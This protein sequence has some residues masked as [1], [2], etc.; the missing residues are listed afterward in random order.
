MNVIICETSEEMSTVAAGL[1]AERIRA[2]PD[3]V[4][5]LATGSTPL[6]MYC[7]LIR[8]HTEEGLGFATVRTFNLDEYVGLPPDHDQSYRRFMDANLFDHINIEKAN[9]RVPDGQAEDLAA[10][11]A[12][13][14][15]DIRSAG[16][17]DLQLLG[18]GSNGHIAFNEPGS[19][20]DS[21]TRVVD[22]TENTIRDNARFFERIEDVP[23]Q[24]VSMGMGSIMDARQVVL[25]ASGENK[26][27]AVATTLEGPVTEEVPA[28]ILQG[29]PNV[30]FVIDRAAARLLKQ[31]YA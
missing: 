9:T 17:I 4:L 3:L 19:P 25:L 24:A 1:F 16:G 29:H 10:G 8:M 26:A 20:A 5:G 2:Q 12:A 15:A 11:C 23:R 31:S 14:E 28:S 18:I 27:D 13:Y 21:R 7:Q 30:T 22:L 6:G